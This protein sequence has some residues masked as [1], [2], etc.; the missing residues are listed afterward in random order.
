MD[1]MKAVMKVSLRVPRKAAQK[2][3]TMV[4]HSVEKM[5]VK[6]AES[7]EMMLVVRKAGLME[8]MLADMM[9]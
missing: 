6:T 3:G 4:E 7:M 1:V 5:D 8:M 2:D 9:V